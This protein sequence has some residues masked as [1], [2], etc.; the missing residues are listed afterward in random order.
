[1]SD[2]T[3]A[4]LLAKLHVETRIPDPRLVQQIDKGKFVADAVGHADITDILLTHDPLWT[5][6]PLA[7]DESGLP[8]ITVDKSGRLAM[9]AW[10]T[11][12]GHRRLEVGTC[13]ATSPDPLKELV[14]DFLRRG[15]MRFGL[16]LA[17]WSKS[18]WE[19][20]GE[21][22]RPGERSSGRKP[23]GSASGENGPQAGNVH[24]LPKPTDAG[25][26]RHPAS[27][28]VLPTDQAIAARAVELGL[29]DDE[30]QDIIRAVTDGRTTSGKDLRGKEPG[31]VFAAMAAKAKAK[32]PA[33]G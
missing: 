16:A 28:P 30:R 9:W 3:A 15:A 32:A 31:L 27:G 26:A 23:W 18:D 14:G 5:W 22:S 6:E 8:K 19:A 20:G 25:I 21:S 12:H 13:M 29:T 2:P 7:Y 4:D 11:V 24:P 1:M 17:L 33:R 10:L